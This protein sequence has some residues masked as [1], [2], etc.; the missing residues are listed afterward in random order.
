MATFTLLLFSSH[1]S[2]L[3]HVTSESTLSSGSDPLA[4]S[5]ASKEKEKG[6]FEDRKVRVCVRVCVRAC[7]RVCVCVRACVCVCVCVCVRY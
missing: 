6:L 3:E 5:Q 7:V 1:D 4:P 2:I